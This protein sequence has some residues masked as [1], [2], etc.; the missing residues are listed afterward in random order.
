MPRQKISY[1]SRYEDHQ[2]HNGHQGFIAN[3]TQGYHDRLEYMVAKHNQV[4]VSHLSVTAPDGVSPARLTKAI[5]GS[6][7]SLKKTLKKEKI[8]AQIGWALEA[9]NSGAAEQKPHIHIGIIK[10][11]SKSQNGLGDALYIDKIL[12]K[13]LGDPARTGY[14]RCN[15]PDLE[16]YDQQ[17]E[18]NT[19]SNMALKIRS[20]KP[21]A[22]KQID[23]ALNWLNYQSKIETKGNA[24]HGQREY[25]FTHLPKDCDKHNG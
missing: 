6:L 14:V 25:G 12:A 8:E 24:P 10:N 3:I 18:C 7:D 13:R 1:D 21:G 15:P 4:A 16:R 17:P 23:N 9:T 22:A 2:L 20:N 5:S 19:K 11:G